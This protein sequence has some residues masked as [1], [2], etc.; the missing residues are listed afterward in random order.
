MVSTNFNDTKTIIHELSV[1]EK[2]E[3]DNFISSDNSELNHNLRY[4]IKTFARLLRK[5]LSLYIRAKMQKQFTNIIYLTT[6]CTDYVK[7]SIR[8]DSPIYYIEEMRKQ[9][10]NNDIRMI[11][12]I[13]DLPK[14]TKISK[15]MPIIIGEK[16][17]ILE[18]TSVKCEVY[19]R[20]KFCNLILYKFPKNDNN[21]QVYGIYSPAFSYLQSPIELRKFEN[22]AL[23]TKGSRKIINELSKN[24]FQADIIHSDKIPYF[25]GSEFEKS[26]SNKIKVLQIVEDFMDEDRTK[27]DLLWAFVHFADKKLIKKFVKDYDTRFLISKIFDISEETIIHNV[28]DFSKCIFKNYKHIKDFAKKENNMARLHMIEKLNK[29]IE[30]MFPDLSGKTASYYPMLSSIKHCDYW[31]VISKTYYGELY[32]EFNMPSAIARNLNKTSEKSTYV[33]LGYDYKNYPTQK[34]LQIYNN[35]DEDNFRTERN[36]NK[37]MLLYELSSEKIKLDF[38]DKS[39]FANPDFIK[40]HGYLDTFYDAPLLFALFENDSFGEGIDIVFNTI[41]K[42][43]EL[44]KN[45]QIILAIDN[46]EKLDSTK[47]IISFLNENSIF[48]GRCIIIENTNNLCLQDD[49]NN[50][51]DATKT[52]Y[53]PKFFSGA[54]MFLA[55]YRKN[56]SNALPLL[57]MHYGCVP[58]VAKSGILNDTIEDIFDNIAVGNGFKTKENLIKENSTGK[59]Y[60]ESLYKALEMYQNNPSSWNLLVK[61]CLKSKIDWTFSKLER[62]NKIYQELI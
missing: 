31:A 25:M 17:F 30:K 58:V 60:Y 5:K 29:K 16:K 18:K 6:D 45:I 37:K 21:I 20:N 26:F 11:V 51:L 34:G 33:S 53:L 22:F 13:L 4:R 27:Q 42:F 50:N 12:P 32:Q 1:N 9:Y 49:Y 7:N 8:F 38:V 24:G 19:Y 62:Y 35:F 57:A 28:K 56:F 23:Y 61:N 48:N 44:N 59:S 54:D 43:F 36:K 3:I 10:P 15:K 41:L 55:P 40:I 46:S 39:L 14:K 47:S 2:M 52:V